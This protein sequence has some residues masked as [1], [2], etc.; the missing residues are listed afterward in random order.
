MKKDYFSGHSKL[1]ATFRPSYPEAWYQFL[2]QHVQSFETAWDCGTGN[3][4]VAKILAPKFQ[5]VYATDISAQQLENAHKADNIFYSV[6]S[7]ERS[8]L[9]ANS[10][11]LITV[12]QAFHWFDA[13]QFYKEVQRVAKPGAIVT[14]WGYNVL[15]ISPEIDAIMNDFYLN[16]TGPY[17]DERRKLIDQ[18]YQSISFPFEE[19]KFPKIDMVVEWSLDHLTGYLTTWSATQKFINVNGFD[20]VIEVREKLNQ[21]WKSGEIK[22]ASFPLFGKMGRV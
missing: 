2:F 10:I 19:I 5:R 15:K 8:E 16:T 6:A 7:A 14:M 21:H 3:G 18:E 1:Y 13:A 9:A 11:N 12:A 20:P 17:W 4:Q 22:K